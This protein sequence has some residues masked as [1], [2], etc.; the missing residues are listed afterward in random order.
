MLATICSVHTPRVVTDCKSLL[1]TATAGAVRATS[2]SCPLAG[3][4]GVVAICVDG[5][6]ARL[7]ALKLLR[8]MPA[9]KS[10]AKAVALRASDGEL[11]TNLEWRANRLADAIARTC[12]LRLAVPRPVTARL[13]V[14]ADVLRTEA[15]TL[16]VVTKAANRHKVA[17]ITDGGHPAT[18]VRR[19]S[20]RPERPSYVAARPWRA[21]VPLPPRELAS[22][23]LRAT[24]VPPA[25][26]S[27]H[28]ALVAARDASRTR[29]REHQ[30]A[31][32][33][34]LRQIV[35]DR[36][37]HARPQSVPAAVRYAAL[38]LRVV[39]REAAAADSSAGSPL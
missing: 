19:D 18:V 5:D 30:A 21:R 38:R 24:S 39:A 6:L 10:L 1:T 4:W 36:A 15:G 12:A 26:V 32:S 3:V 20:V 28:C 16:G 8:W 9:H 22:V 23:R 37:S 14:A 11:V 25:A 29:R 33:F 7:V 27:R 35:S 17:V 34:V 13:R 31:D 2:A